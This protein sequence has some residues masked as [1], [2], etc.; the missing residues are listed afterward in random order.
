M[1]WHEHI[2]ADPAIM[3]G[4]PAIKGTRIPVEMILEHL[5]FGRTIEQVLVSWPLLTRDD[6][7]AA[8]AYSNSLKLSPLPN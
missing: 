6:V 8:L 4:K 1:D 3:V 7:L 5:A 2:H